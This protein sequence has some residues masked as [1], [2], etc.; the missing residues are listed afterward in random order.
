M[1]SILDEKEQRT[2]ESVEQQYAHC[3]Y[4]LTN[5]TDLENPKGNLYCV[6]TSNETYTDICR[7]L[8][9][10]GKESIP[11]ILMG[12]YDSCYSFLRS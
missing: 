4:I 2:A 5:Y 11:S 8:D 9:E 1:L 6:S 12:S 10:L 7:I 3:T